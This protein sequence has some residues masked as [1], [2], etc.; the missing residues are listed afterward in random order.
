[1]ET[2]GN[3]IATSIYEA[4]LPR[5]ER[6]TLAKLTGKQ[7]DDARTCFMKMKYQKRAYF[8]AEAHQKHSS[9]LEI[10]AKRADLSQRLMHQQEMKAFTAA[11]FGNDDDDDGT[12]ASSTGELSAADLGYEDE[13]QPAMQG[14]SN[15]DLGYDDPNEQEEIARALANRAMCGGG[16]MRRGSFNGGLMVGRRNSGRGNIMRQGSGR[17]LMGG[18]GGGGSEHQKR[19]PPRSNST[20]STESVRSGDSCSGSEGGRRLARRNSN[21]KLQVQE[22][23]TD[24]ETTDCESEVDERKAARRRNRRKKSDDSGNHNSYNSSSDMEEPFSESRRDGKAKRRGSNRMSLT[25]QAP[26]ESSPTERKIKRRGSNRKLVVADTDTENETESA[27]TERKIKRR[28]SNRK[29]MVA[30]TDT[31]N[32]AE[33][34]PTER[35]I[36]RCGSNRKLAATDTDTE[37]ETETD[38]SPTQRKIKRRGSNRKLVLVDTDSESE[39]EIELLLEEAAST[40]KQLEGKMKRRGSNGKSLF[41]Q[42]IAQIAAIDN[43]DVQSSPSLSNCGDASRESSGS[44]RSRGSPGQRNGMNSSNCGSCC[45]SDDD[46]HHGSNDESAAERKARRR[47][48]RRKSKCESPKSVQRSDG[49]GYGS[50]SR[51]AGTSDGSSGPRPRRR[52]SLN[53][54]MALKIPTAPTLDL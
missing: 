8:S 5:E 50:N 23:H 54:A 17:R 35:K 26:S 21:R 19:M 6:E 34:A 18:G 43:H 27:P 7:E 22:N 52:P 9:W 53:G 2:S 36:K 37:T 42:G 33:S 40:K 11:T 44:H 16:T 48:G 13:E 41:A 28:G 29:L 15:L 49:L 4:N 38:S 51:S 25:D 10:V 1:M 30:D 47:S 20:D 39:E 3:A 32:E 46:D 45:S 14:S 24:C 12:V 31:E